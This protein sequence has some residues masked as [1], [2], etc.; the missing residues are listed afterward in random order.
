MEYLFCDDWLIFAAD[1]NG[2]IYTVNTEMWDLWIDLP[3]GSDQEPYA[4]ERF[5]LAYAFKNW[6]DLDWQPAIRENFGQLHL[7]HLDRFKL[8]PGKQP[9]GLTPEQIEEIT[10]KIRAR[11]FITEDRK[12]EVVDALVDLAKDLAAGKRYETHEYNQSIHY[13]TLDRFNSAGKAEPTHQDDDAD[14]SDQ[15][16]ECPSCRQLCGPEEFT[17]HGVCLTCMGL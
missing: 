7:I 3:D 17:H 13:Y 1:K 11:G 10:Y 2:Y 16:K 5:A 14:D 4:L 15:P 6:L 8:D 9:A 12:I